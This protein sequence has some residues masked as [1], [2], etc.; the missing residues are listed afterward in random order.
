M[1]DDFGEGVIVSAE[2]AAAIIAAPDDKIIPVDHPAPVLDAFAAGIAA[3]EARLAGESSVRPPPPAP[4]P[5]TEAIDEKKQRRPLVKSPPKSETRTEGS[6]IGKATN[7]PFTF[8]VQT[9]E[10][11]LARGRNRHVS[12]EAAIEWVM[13]NLGNRRAEP[14][15]AP[16]NYAWS[17]LKL[18]MT[19]PVQERKFHED[20]AKMEEKRKKKDEERKKWAD[21]GRRMFELFEQVE[22]E[23][24]RQDRAKG[25][26]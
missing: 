11:Q 14:D 21:D 10:L 12:R 20:V 16:S 1:S 13:E 15:T 19:N 22:A 23:F 18:V 5:E 24:G 26:A 3:A 2:D 25:A 8:C 6:P 17:Y 4:L 9:A 7:W